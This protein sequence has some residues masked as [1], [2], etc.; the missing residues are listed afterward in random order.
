MNTITIEGSPIQID[1]EGYLVNFDEWREEIGSYI[2]KEDHIELTDAHFEIIQIMR[3]YFAENGDVP[4][5]RDFLKILENK[6]GADKGTS[7]YFG[8]LFPREPLKMCAKI[9]GLPQLRGCM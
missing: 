9:A 2:S 5:A 6:L 8:S 3:E 1:S 4:T 7:H